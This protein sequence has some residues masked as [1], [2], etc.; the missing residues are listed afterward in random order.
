MGKWSLT[1]DLRIYCLSAV[2]IMLGPAP[3]PIFTIGNLD[4][5][6]LI[7]NSMVNSGVNDYVLITGTYVSK[8]MFHRCCYIILPRMFH[9]NEMGSL[10][11]S[12]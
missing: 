10:R 3:V 6:K 7:V 9:F 4:F 12:S 2:P 8:D 5:G 11:P 1:F